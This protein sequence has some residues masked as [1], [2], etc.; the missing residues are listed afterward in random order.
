MLLFMIKSNVVRAQEKTSGTILF[1]EL[2]RGWGRKRR[3]LRE[4]T[5]ERGRD[6]RKREGKEE[7]KR[8]RDFEFIYFNCLTL[9]MKV[10]LIYSRWDQFLPSRSLQANR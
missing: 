9:Q 4:H 8:D 10:S 2:F 5:W 3:E 7:R 6:K 1:G